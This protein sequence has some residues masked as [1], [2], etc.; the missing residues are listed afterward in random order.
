MKATTCTRANEV[1]YQVIEEVLGSH[2]D[3]VFTY[4][5]KLVTWVL[6]SAWIKARKRAGC[7][8]ARV[9]DLKHTFGRR[10]CAAEVSFEDRQDFL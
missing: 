3:Y 5:G 1:A 4:R 10:L 7:P 6:N 2:Q 8:Q 9:H